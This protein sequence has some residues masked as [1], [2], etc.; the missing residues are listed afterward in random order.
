M[1]PKEMHSSPVSILQAGM[2]P[3][4]FLDRKIDPV[5]TGSDDSV[6]RPAIDDIRR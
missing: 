1:K 3:I 4:T 2:C 6:I 5:P